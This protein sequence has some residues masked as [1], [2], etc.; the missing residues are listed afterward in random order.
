ML[1]KLK[2]GF[3][4]N[5]Q[6][7][8]KITKN[9]ICK[10]DDPV[11]KAA[12]DLAWNKALYVAEK[13]HPVLGS[14]VHLANTIRQIREKHVVHSRSAKCGGILGNTNPDIVDFLAVF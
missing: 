6:D 8:D 14:V 11:I 4:P 1:S 5:E 9:N 13:I 7:Y 2:S 12:R 3:R 10:I